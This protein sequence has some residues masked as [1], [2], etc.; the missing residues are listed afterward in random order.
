V[1][2]ASG[3]LADGST[4]HFNPAVS[5]Q[6]PALLYANGLVY[7]AFGSFCDLRADQSRGWLLAWIGLSLTPVPANY[8]TNKR[9]TAPS[10][11]YLSAIWMSGYGPA[12]A[13]FGSPI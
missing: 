12:T 6:R 2:S 7:A 4:Y 3:T 5:R 1:V 8:L 13:G 11:F 10:N 9:T